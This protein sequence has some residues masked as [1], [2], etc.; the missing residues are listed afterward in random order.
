[1]NMQRYMYKLNNK[2]K[3]LN[4]KIEK[5]QLKR[6]YL[7]NDIALLKMYSLPRTMCDV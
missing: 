6:D 1:M 7:D 5:L 4:S 2:R 3:R